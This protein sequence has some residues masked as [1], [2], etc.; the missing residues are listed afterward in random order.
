[1]AITFGFYNSMNGDRKYDAVQ[2]SSIFDGVIRDGVFQSIGEYLVTKPGTGM[3]VLV[4]PGKAWFD[5]TWTINDSIYP[6]EIEEADITLKRYDAVV[7]ETDAN[8]TVRQNSIFIVKGTPATDPSK[9]NIISEGSRHQ[10]PLAYILVKP[11]ATNIEAEDIEIMVGKSECPFV[12]SILESVSID[13]LFSKWESEFQKWFDNL[14]MQMEGDV[15]TNLQKQIDEINRTTASEATKNIYGLTSENTPDDVFQEIFSLGDIKVT[16]RNDLG[17]HWLLC[18]GATFSPSEYPELAKKCTQQAIDWKEVSINLPNSGY[19]IDG[20]CYCNGYWFL[21]QLTNDWAFY[22][23]SNFNGPW[24]K[25]TLATKDFA[26]PQKVF[27]LDGKYFGWSKN[28]YISYASSPKGP[29]TKCPTISIDGSTF[30]REWTDAAVASS[31]MFL[32]CQNYDTNENKVLWSDDPISGDWH[33]IDFRWPSGAFFEASGTE[34]IITAAAEYP[35]NTAGYTTNLNSESPSFTKQSFMSAGKTSK[36][37]L[38]GW[39]DIS[40]YKKLPISESVLVQNTTVKGRVIE[41]GD[42]FVVSSQ[43]S[44]IKVI[45]KNTFADYGDIT[46][47]SKSGVYAITDGDRVVRL[48]NNRGKAYTALKSELTLAKLP[49]ISVSNAYCYIRGK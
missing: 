15:A 8:K 28:E 18:N 16:T 27:F 9:P 44:K 42:F 12:T 4:S 22:Y 39:K 10:H 32:L 40:L 47:G 46:V 35:V 17:D 26:P 34:A 6:L 7:L 3:Q 14:Q 29:W 13:E 11:R 19:D 21:G 37:W 25:A 36:G 23:S 41:V 48:S 43:N 38:A 45:D 20:Y 31:R 2:L 49:T 33:Q 1:M 30:G 5:H 24:R